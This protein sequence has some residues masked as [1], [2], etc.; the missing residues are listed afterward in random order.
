MVDLAMK[1][2]ENI[3]RDSFHICSNGTGQLRKEESEMDSTESV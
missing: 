1:F 3:R 2:P